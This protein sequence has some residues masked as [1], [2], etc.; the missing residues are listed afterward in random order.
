M[1]RQVL[2]TA[3]VLVF[4]FAASSFAGSG[5]GNVK[6]LQNLKDAFKGETTASAKYAAYSKKASEEGYEKIALLFSA[7]SKSESIHAANHNAAIEQLGGKMDPVTPE[8]DVKSTKENLQDAIAGESYEVETMYP[9]FLK[10]ASGENANIALL[11]FNYAYQTEKKHKVLYANALKELNAGNESTLPAQYMV[12]STCGNT[13][14]G[15]APKRCGISM[16][17]KE[18]FYTIK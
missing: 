3:M 18:R 9:A 16:T 14:E 8:F 4:S 2:I 5:Q 6:T 7:A 17:P 13:Y 10:A 1:N 11:S 15:D 12:C